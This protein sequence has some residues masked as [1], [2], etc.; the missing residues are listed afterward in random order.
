MFFFFYAFILF[1]S[2]LSIFYHYIVLHSS[3]IY[4]IDA[5]EAIYVLRSKL[6]LLKKTI[7][8]AV[9]IVCILRFILRSAIIAIKNKS[10]QETK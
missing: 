6:T 8:T 7:C 1:F 3:T 4:I 9:L 5:R 10:P 2:F